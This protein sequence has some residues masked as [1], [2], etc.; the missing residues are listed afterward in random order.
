MIGSPT[1]LKKKKSNQSIYFTFYFRL[2]ICQCEIWYKIYKPMMS[3]SAKALE[4]EL[5][6]GQHL[7]SAKQSLV[8]FAVFRGW[9][10]PVLYSKISLFVVVLSVS[11]SFPSPFGGLTPFTVLRD[12][13][14][15][16][17]T[18]HRTCLSMVTLPTPGLSPASLG[19]L[20][21]GLRCMVRCALDSSD[22]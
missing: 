20:H 22:F 11:G 14:G 12:W 2:D 18:I 21:E 17:W 6:P 3:M 15:L 4:S 16:D 19:V 10:G 9:T 1:D 8:T 7:D 5:D 13:T